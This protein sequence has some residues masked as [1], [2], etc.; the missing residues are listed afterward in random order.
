MSLKRKIASTLC[1]IGF[2]VALIFIACTDEY[3]LGKTREELTKEMFEVDS[4][5][6][7][8]QMQLDSTSTD[9]QKFYIDAQRINTGHE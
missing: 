2:L 7:T 3:Y 9:F 6:M 4:L 8:I 5:L 1:L